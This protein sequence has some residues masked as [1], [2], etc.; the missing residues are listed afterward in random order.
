MVERDKCEGC[1]ELDVGELCFVRGVYF[2]LCTPN[3]YCIINCA[4]LLIIAV[5]F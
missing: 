4:L 5:G 1:T 2:M 3:L